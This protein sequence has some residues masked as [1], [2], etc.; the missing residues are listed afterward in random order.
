MQIVQILISNEFPHHLYLHRFVIGVVF[1]KNS[2]VAFKAEKPEA[3]NWNE[4]NESRGVFV[5]DQYWE[6]ISIVLEKLCM[7]QKLDLHMKL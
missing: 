4:S 6:L 5:P 2:I 7:I 1:A 3:I